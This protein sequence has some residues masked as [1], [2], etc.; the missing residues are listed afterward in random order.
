MWRGARLTEGGGSGCCCC[1]ISSVD[2]G[3]SLDTIEAFDEGGV[4]EVEG[5]S[6]RSTTTTVTLSLLPRSMAALVRTLAAIR[7]A[8]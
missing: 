3:S 8:D 2:F 6:F 5:L 4:E 1:G 7:T